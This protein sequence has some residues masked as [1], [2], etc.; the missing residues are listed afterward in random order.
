MCSFSMI[1]FASHYDISFCHICLLSLRSVLF[2]NERQRVDPEETECGEELET[3]RRR[4]RDYNEDIVYEK[5]IYFQ[6]K[7]KIII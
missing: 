2:P 1:V 3:L 4:R 5:V 6:E 7:E